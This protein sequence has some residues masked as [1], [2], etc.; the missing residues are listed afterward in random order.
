MKYARIENGVAVELFAPQEGFTLEDSWH[1][2]IAALFAEVP[3]NV[4]AGSAIDAKGK[5]TIAPAPVEPEAQ[6]IYP[7]PTP[8]AFQM[9]FTSSERIAIRKKVAEPDE[10]LAD[11]WAIVTNPQLTEVDLGLS[12]VQKALAYLVTLEIITEDRKTQILS[13]QIQ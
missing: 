9:L 8:M 12:S 4:T 13:A 6:V 1:P 7:K 3:A 2:E 5:W 11:W 10:V